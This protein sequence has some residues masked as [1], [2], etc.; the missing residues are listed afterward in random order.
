[1]NTIWLIRICYKNSG[2]RG[3]KIRNF[4]SAASRRQESVVR[5][6]R[7]EKSM[8]FIVVVNHP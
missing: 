8:F 1:M 6:Q 3:R 4:W 5:D 7:S 2:G